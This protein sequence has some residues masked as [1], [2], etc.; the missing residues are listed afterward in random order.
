MRVRRF[1]VSSRVCWLIVASITITS[2]INR[3]AV[4]ART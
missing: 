2:T 1:F 4:F 3:A